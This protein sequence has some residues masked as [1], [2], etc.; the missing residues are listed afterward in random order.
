VS[1]PLR[2]LLVEDSPSD[3]KLVVLA[4]RSI[5]RTIEPER[6]DEAAA[7]R[8]ALES[9]RWDLVTCDWAMPRFSA[10][11]ALALVKEMGLD[12]PFIIVSGTVGETTAVDAMRAGAHDYV[13]KDNLARL[14]PAVEREL[15]ERETREAKRLAEVALRE[16]EERYRRIIETTNEG[17]WLIGADEKTT[18]VNGRMAQMLGCNA[19]DVVG[20]SP[21]EVLDDEGVSMF[22]E[23]LADLRRGDPFQ[24]EGRFGKRGGR[25]F[26][27]L[28]E[29]SPIFDAA[30]CFEGALAM[31]RDVSERREEQKAFRASET[32]FKRL[33]DSGLIFI[34]ITDSTGSMV[35]VNDAF[36]KSLG[37]TR[38]ELLDLGSDWHDLTTPESKE[39]DLAARAQLIATGVAAPWEREVFRKDG[40]RIPLLMGAATLAG[41]ERIAIAIDLTARKRAESANTD[42]MRIAS[43]AADVGIALTH[44]GALADILQR[45]AEAIVKHMDVALARVWTLDPSAAVLELRASAGMYTHLDGSHSRV[46]VGALKIGVIAKERRS[47]V[48][49]DIA[50]DARIS[51]PAWAKSEGM[52][53]FAGHPLLVGDQLVGV[54]GVFSRHPMPDV[55]LKGLES[56][57][58]EMAIGI[59]RSLG[60]DL[61]EALEAQLRQ[62]QKMEAV[63][64]LAGGVAH[65]FNNVLSVILSYADLTLDALRPG[66]PMR[67]DIEEIRKAG[68]RAAS[69][70]RQLLMFSRQQVLE[71]KILDMRDV[72]DGM[73]GMLRRLLGADIDLV[74]VV[75]AAGRVRADLHSLEQVILNLVVNARD[76]MPTGGKLTVESSDAQ[77]GEE[78]SARHIGLEAGPH[79][80][81]SVSDTGSGMDPATQARIFEPFFTTKPK[82]KGT[83]L[84]LSTVFGIVKQCGGG[85]W[86]YSEPGIGT[87]FKIYFPRVDGPV[88]TAP[89]RT[90][91]A[92]AG[93]HET[94]LLV[95]D[96]DMVRLVARGILSRHGYDVLEARNPGEAIV[97]AEKHGATIQL[98]LTD[99]VMPQMSGPELAKR[100]V[101]DRPNTKVIFMS[102]YT[103]DSIV[104]HGVLQS[105]LAYLQKPF[106]PDAL[107]R[108]VRTTLDAAATG[109]NTAA[110][111]PPDQSLSS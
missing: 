16:A 28:V 95:E 94:I 111:G 34:A 100:L 51:D 37:Y 5:E 54:L 3:A 41:E 88:E 25:A 103:D 104:R 45:C 76:A 6:V 98:L 48:S 29:T 38:Q 74:L 64:R 60:D 87:T 85:I 4:L 101:K 46:P 50:S 97:H 68:E 86:V 55:A 44:G 92:V 66:D 61:R 35:D 73:D 18:F 67:A 53:A 107:L 78:Y 83:G 91:A 27:A 65:D 75:G 23:S 22:T 70:T 19:A 72:L 15:R 36:A 57:A 52:V 30:G 14:A 84:G 40:S 93:G 10:L 7:M 62:A 105:E 106:T 32:R 21:A 77:L 59:H 2:V 12:I 58:N 39:A 24:V 20:V 63:G 8:A 43:M 26:W 11:A 56:I 99:V 81:L 82:E 109:T 79:V 102:G 96:D 13:L 33:W 90:V 49:N 1:A 9:G 17:V 47:H 89:P 31:V 71:S 69:L 110:A 108:K 42:R 80:M